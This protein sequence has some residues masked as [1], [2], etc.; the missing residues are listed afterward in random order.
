VVIVK[1]KAR[2]TA[3]TQSQTPLP[4]LRPAPA[5]HTSPDIILDIDTDTASDSASRPNQVQHPIAISHLASRALPNSASS[6]SAHAP[7]RLLSRI[8]TIGDACRCS[9]AAPP[10]LSQHETISHRTNL[11]FAKARTRS[12]KE[13]PLLPQR[14]RIPPSDAV[15]GTGRSSPDARARFAF[16]V[17][18]G[19]ARCT[20]LA[21]HLPG[22]RLLDRPLNIPSATD[23]ASSHGLPFA[24]LVVS[25]WHVASSTG[26]HP[27]A[28]DRTCRAHQ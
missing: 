15:S 18:I 20:R 2:L 3:H 26:P 1:A 14:A 28:E 11:P 13:Y 8:A 22:R 6:R 10:P 17:S 24:S 21:H 9:P 12:V 4:P 19:C 23:H 7:I 27:A 5:L 25:E 16:A